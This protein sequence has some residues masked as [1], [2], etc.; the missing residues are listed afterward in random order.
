MKNWHDNSR[1]LISKLASIFSIFSRIVS[2]ESNPIV[3]LQIEN[4]ERYSKEF[5]T[6]TTLHDLVSHFQSVRY[7]QLFFLIKNII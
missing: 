3:A 7:L 5:P 6:N 2:L 4:G 1:P